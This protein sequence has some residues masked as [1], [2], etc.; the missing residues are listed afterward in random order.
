V[1]ED[2][3]PPIKFLGK[4]LCYYGPV[5]LSWLQRTLALPDDLLRDAVHALEETGLVLLD[6]FTEESRAPEICDAANLEA[7]LRML[8]RSRKPAFEALDLAYLPLFLAT[9]Q[10]VIRQGG[11]MDDLRERLEQLLGIPL[12]AGAWEEEVL[13]ARLHPYFSAWLDSLMHTSDLLWFGCGQRRVSFAFP[14]DLDLFLELAGLGEDTDADLLARLIPDPKGR[15]SL[16]AI[17]SSSGLPAATVTTEL[18]KLAWRG[19]LSND[20]FVSVRKGI[21]SRFVRREAEQ[22]RE[23]RRIPASRW[24]RAQDSSGNWYLLPGKKGEPDVLEREERNKD[25]VRVLLERYGI[26][27]KELLLREMP[28]LQWGRLFRTLRI[29]EMSGELLSGNFFS[30]IAGLQF[31]SHEAYRLLDQGL[32]H[33]MVYWVN[34]ADPASLCGSGLE[35]VR[36]QLPARLP[37]THLVYNGV[38]LVLVSR[39]YG[40][41]LDIKAQPDDPRLHEYLSF[42][43]VLLT[44]EFNPRKRISVERINGEPAAASAYSKPLREFGFQE[45]YDGL[46]LWRKY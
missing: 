38:R 16:P 23:L 10:G 42:F 12:Y 20:S 39:R 7:L 13:P 3:P 32:P 46:E 9:F 14:E 43:R 22:G 25:R 15:Y 19:E 24:N 45:A 28:T 26:L 5:Q 37:S 18:W 41:E 17:C 36:E 27:F 33:D 40:K 44:R 8:R 35:G 11:S 6:Q 31:I 34:A 30:G 21:L 4:W 2:D 1:D 29:M